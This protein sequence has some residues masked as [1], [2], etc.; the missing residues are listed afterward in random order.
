[1]SSLVTQMRE[2]DDSLAL[3][4]SIEWLT[5]SLK[6]IADDRSIDKKAENSSNTTQGI[7][8]WKLACFFFLISHLLIFEVLFSSFR[9]FPFLLSTI[10][11]GNVEWWKFTSNLLFCELSIDLLSWFSSSTSSYIQISRNVWGNVGIVFVFKLTYHHW[12]HSL[13]IRKL[14]FIID[15]SKSSS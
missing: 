12:Y 10:D 8:M 6:Q 3:L 2:H 1:M 5:R 11:L 15:F 4:D 9:I 14:L 7:L 13:K